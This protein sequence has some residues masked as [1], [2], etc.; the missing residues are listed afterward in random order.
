MENKQD[1]KIN[2]YFFLAVILLFGAFLLFSL[3]Q[4]FTAFLAAVMFYV[5]SKAPVEWLVKKKRWRK[6]WAAILVIVV[7]FFII[8]LPISLLATMLYNKIITVAGNTQ[9]IMQYFKKLDVF[10]RQRLH[11][12]LLSDKN[13][14]EAQAYVAN[15]ISSALNQGLNLFSAITMMYFFLY[16]MIININRMEAAIIYFLPFKRHKI[17]LFGDELQAQTFSNAIGV[18]LI[19]VTQGL[20]TYIAFLIA[21]LNEAGFWAVITG[22]SSIIPIVGTGLITIP[23]GIYLLV[24]HHTWEGIFVLLWGIIVL[25]SIDNVLRFMLAKRMADVHPVVTVL[26]VIVGLNYFGLTGLIFG[27]LIISYFIILLK[28]YHAEFHFPG[29][30]PGAKVS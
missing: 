28:I 8:L 16:F 4:F 19:A 25:S 23:A 11:F 30:K 9:L 18:P 21:G 24:M 27:P 29:L 22:F 2:R 5:L 17:K 14:A 20:F 26:G 10:L 3:L 1:Y 12:V 6:S 13:M 7:S 15:F